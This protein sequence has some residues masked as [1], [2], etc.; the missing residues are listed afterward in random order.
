MGAALWAHVTLN[1]R[2]FQT[3]VENVCLASWVAALCV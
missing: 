1:L 2:T 3:I